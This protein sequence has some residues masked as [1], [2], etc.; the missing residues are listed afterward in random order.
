MI[1]L[2]IFQSTSPPTCVP[3]T[4]ILAFTVTTEREYL[5]PEQEEDGKSIARMVVY[6]AAT[7]P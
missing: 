1:A 2:G 5:T 7:N 3:L 4:Q 6:E